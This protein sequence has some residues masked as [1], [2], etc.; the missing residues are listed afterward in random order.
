LTVRS[1]DKKDKPAFFISAT[2]RPSR[3]N[4]ARD[5]ERTRQNL[6]DAAYREFSHSGYHAASVEK[7]CTRAGVSKQILSHHF[8]SKENAYLAV[9]EAAYTAF[10]SNDPR[11]ELNAADPRAA[12]R[13]FV[14]FTFDHV[15]HNRDFVNLLS[16]ENVNKGKIIRKSERLKSIYDPMIHRIGMLLK[17]GAEAG[18]FRPGLDA[19]QVYISINALCFF[20]ISNCHTLSA[21]L[22][23]DL[24]DDAALDERREHVVDFV[25]A[26]ITA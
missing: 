12:L 15:R 10:R 21:V 3:S 4:G 22:G 1:T 13:D 20:S 25:M 17:A 26:A 8:G 11:L 7:I 24:A 5:P 23:T 2:R 19:R 9:L 18:F 16:G 14:L 6:L